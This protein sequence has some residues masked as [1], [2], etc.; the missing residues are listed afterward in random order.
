MSLKVVW[1]GV[2]D[3]RRPC[4]AVEST[5]HNIC[6]HV[7]VDADNSVALAAAYTD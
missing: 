3:G 1:H 4:W 5:R 2:E 7:R 6:S